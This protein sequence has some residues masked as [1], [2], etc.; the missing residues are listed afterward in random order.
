MNDNKG[1]LFKLLNSELV[2]SAT[3]R[4]SLTVT[5]GD[6]ALFVPS[7]DMTNLAPCNYEEADSRITVHVADVIMLGFQKFDVVVLAVAVLPQLG[8]AELWIAFGTDNN[9]RY[10]PAHDLCIPWSTEIA[11][12]SRVPCFHRLRYCI[13]VCPSGKK[14]LHG[15]YGQHMMN[16]LQPSVSCTILHSKYLKRQ[17]V[18]WSI[19]LSFFMTGQQHV[20]LSMKL[21]ASIHTQR[22]SDVSSSSNQGCFTATY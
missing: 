11:G 22:P 20:P 1:E 18:H 4:K 5:S 14:R 8:W 10:I 3:E 17:K 19:S 15:K 9:F 6:T 7:R 13:P 16:S 21:K 12:T 2:A